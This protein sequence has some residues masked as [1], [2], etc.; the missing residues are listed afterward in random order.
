[1]TTRGAC[2]VLQLQPD[3][4]GIFRQIHEIA[5]APAPGWQFAEL[6]WRVEV[7]RLRWLSVDNLLVTNENEG[8]IS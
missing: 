8:R 1:M 5:V 6:T 4:V 3:D 7:V 2:D